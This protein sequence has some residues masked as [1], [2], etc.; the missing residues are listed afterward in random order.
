MGFLNSL[1]DGEMRAVKKALRSLDTADKHLQAK[2]TERAKGE[3]DKARAQ[4]ESLDLKSSAHPDDY[5]AAVARLSDAYM[6]A[7]LPTPALEVL[8]RLSRS[9]PEDRQSVLLQAALAED[10]NFPKQP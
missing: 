2:E 6:N 4:L 1:M 3:M 8:S 10:R 7:G 9:V 5:R